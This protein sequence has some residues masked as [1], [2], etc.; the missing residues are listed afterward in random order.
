M[1]SYP[2]LTT[3]EKG[4]LPAIKGQGMT[5]IRNQRAR[6]P[7]TEKSKT[8]PQWGGG[9]N[10]DSKKRRIKGKIHRLFGMAREEGGLRGKSDGNLH[11]YCR[12]E[13]TN[14]KETIPESKKRASNDV[15]TNALRGGKKKG[16]V[17]DKNSQNRESNTPNW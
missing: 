5:H 8:H 10:V 4:V 3:G 2:F 11:H 12:P 14:K 17:K 9:P 15:V 7:P 1:Q 16:G 13:N 6:Y